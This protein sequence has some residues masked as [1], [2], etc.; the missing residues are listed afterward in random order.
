M[1]E[2]SAA[3]MAKDPNSLFET[4]T[5]AVIGRLIRER[6]EVKQQIAFLDT[7]ARHLAREFKNLS[8]AL[9]QKPQAI[10]VDGAQDILN[11]ERL[12]ALVGEYKRLIAKEIQLN[13]LLGKFGLDI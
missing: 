3:R 10:V 13:E 8:R 5:D 6:S 11:P 1:L 2:N 4:E 7:Q 12:R 9:K